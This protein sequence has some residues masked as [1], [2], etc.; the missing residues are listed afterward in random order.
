FGVTRQQASA[1]AGAATATR[2]SPLLGARTVVACPQLDGKVDGVHEGW[3]GAAASTIACTRM[4]ARMGGHSARTMI[5]AEL[6]DLPRIPVD[7]FPIEAFEPVTARDTQIANA[8]VHA[9]AWLDG[10]IARARDH[11]HVVLVLRASD[12]GRELARGSAD[13]PQPY[14]A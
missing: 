5:P 13:S 14:E 2:P 12:D 3:L 9:A 11:V 6:L 4:Q 8:K 7:N 10:E 1:P